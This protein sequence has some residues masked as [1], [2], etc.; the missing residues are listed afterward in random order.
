MWYGPGGGRVGPRGCSKPSQYHHGQEIKPV[1]PSLRYL[2]SLSNQAC[3]GVTSS[4]LG[5]LTHR[6]S[7]VASISLP[8]LPVIPGNPVFLCLTLQSQPQGPLLFI[9]RQPPT[10]RPPQSPAQLPSQSLNHLP[11]KLSWTTHPSH[12]GLCE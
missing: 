1:G 2:S 11:P 7:M 5:F 9:L 12:H 6:E 4:L 3:V 10:V 8:Q